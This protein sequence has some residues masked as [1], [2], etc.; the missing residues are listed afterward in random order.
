M[1]HYPFGQAAYIA[2]GWVN[3]ALT[4]LCFMGALFQWIE[5]YRRRQDAGCSAATDLL[6][7]RQLN[8]SF[9]GAFASVVF[10][11]SAQVFEHFLVWPR[12]AS[13]V[14]YLLII[15][16]VHR[17]RKSA[18][19]RLSVIAFGALLSVG[20]VGMTLH[21]EVASYLHGLSAAA[22]IGVACLLAIGYLHQIQIIRRHGRTG[23]L[24]LR[25]NQFILMMDLS[26]LAF[27]LAIGI[28]TAWPVALVSLVSL[29]TKLYVL[30]LFRWTR[31]SPKAQAKRLAAARP[32]TQL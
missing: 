9:L 8:S 32:S 1:E 7:L 12:L 31:V 17:D 29:W 15:T 13:A 27:A 16:E 11:Y 4:S 6:S 25:M 22:L 26:T 20:I 2:A 5:I 24:S 18:A 23:A 30:W 28:G 21:K 14:I 3:V 19:T 10:G